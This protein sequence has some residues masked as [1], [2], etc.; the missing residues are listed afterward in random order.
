MWSYLVVLEPHHVQLFGCYRRQFPPTP[1][2]S[3]P[4]LPSWQLEQTTPSTVVTKSL[5][6]P[7]GDAPPE[8]INSNESDR[9]GNNEEEVK[10]G[11]LENTEGA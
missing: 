7:S 6:K 4:S 8:E 10:I 3:S 1:S 2:S 9:T 5:V 11:T